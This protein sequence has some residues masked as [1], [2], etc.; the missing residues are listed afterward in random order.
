MSATEMRLAR[1]EYLLQTI[2]N[3]KG[4]IKFLDL[5]AEIAVFGTSR[6]TFWEYLD[7]LKITNKITM[8]PHRSEAEIEIRLV[9]EVK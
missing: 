7:T 8:S 1:L 2:R 6:R 3:H 4:K 5:F 9:K